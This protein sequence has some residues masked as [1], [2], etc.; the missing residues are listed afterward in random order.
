MDNADHPWD[1]L[2]DEI[3]THA[4]IRM[5]RERGEEVPEPWRSMLQRGERVR[6]GLTIARSA[7]MATGKPVVG[8]IACVPTPRSLPALSPRSQNEPETV[9]QW[10]SRQGAASAPGATRRLGPVLAQRTPL[11]AGNL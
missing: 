5:Y 2:N 4:A 9:H 3:S 8:Y 6:S 10:K 11:H 7:S 1:M